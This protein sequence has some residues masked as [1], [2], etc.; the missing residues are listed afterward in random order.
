MP[1]CAVVGRPTA[2]LGAETVVAETLR[3][4]VERAL[5]GG[6]D[7]IWVLDGSAQPRPGALD[8]LLD[9]LARVDG[10][11]AASLLTGVVVTADGR[12][13]P[14]RTPWYRR[15]QIDVALTSA[16]SALAPV[17]GSTGPVLVHRAAAAAHPPRRGAPIAPG[18]V[19]E[20]TAHVLR[21]RTGYLVPESESL[22][23]AT[24]PDPLRTPATAARLLAGRAL[25][26]LDRVGLVLELCER[27]GLR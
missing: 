15:F 7:W 14:N 16:D 17:R 1:V 23:V 18:A 13:D 11:P 5:A 25:S 24:H 10:L 21:S 26:P 12:V 4:G 8:R 27:V 3:A 9:G 19:L 6:A 20:W 22:A 2:G